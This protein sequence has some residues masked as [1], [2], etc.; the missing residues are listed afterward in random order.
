MNGNPWGTQYN[1]IKVEPYTNVDSHIEPDKYKAQQ[2]V[3]YLP[4]NSYNSNQ[5][6][7]QYVRIENPKV[8]GENYK[9]LIN[10]Y[11]G[12]DYWCF[13]IGPEDSQEV[14]KYSVFIAKDPVTEIS[15]DLQNIINDNHVEKQTYTSKIHIPQLY[16]HENIDL[17]EKIDD[18]SFNNDDLLCI[19]PQFSK[20]IMSNINL[21]SVCW[22]FKNMTTLTTIKTNIPQS[23]PYIASSEKQLLDSGYWTVTMR[24]KFVS[25]GEEHVITKNSAFI[26]K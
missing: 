13:G 23:I 15:E 19:V 7:R 4:I 21:N 8:D 16:D 6:Y 25:S 20:S 11:N 26:I 9:N 5:Y 14:H 2:I 17:T 1:T 3:Y 22:E 12:D 24:F 18:C 10:D